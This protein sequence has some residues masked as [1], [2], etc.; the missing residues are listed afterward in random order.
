MTTH[1]SIFAWIILWTE[2]LVGTITHGVEKSQ[3]QLRMHVVTVS[4]LLQYD[5][6][7][8]F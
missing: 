1:S 5:P 3:I 6:Y 8:S 7:S 4:Y 2:E